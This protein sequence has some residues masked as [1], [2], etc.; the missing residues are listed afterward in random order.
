MTPSRRAFTLIELLVVI[1]IMAILMALLLPAVQK[2]REA[3][4]K[5]RCGN[6]LK[7]IGI[8]M[9]MH[10][11]DHNKF[12]RGQYNYMYS[13]EPYTNSQRY[14]WFHPI[15]CYIEQNE[16]HKSFMEYRKA[17]KEMWD[18]PGIPNVIKTLI[19]PSDR[20]SPKTLTSQNVHYFH[21][22]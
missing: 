12:P 4:N 3:A 2:V 18:N 16:M 19:C 6:N 22:N 9:H 13:E 7:Q 5:M 10:H 11:S 1:A 21:G 8:A 15:L 20:N 17:N 14:C